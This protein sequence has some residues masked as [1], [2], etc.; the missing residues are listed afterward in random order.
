M[1]IREIVEATIRKY[2]TR[3]PYEL[4][5]LTGIKIVRCELGAIRGYYFKKFRFKQILL[6]C[7]LEHNDEKF[8]LAHEI[9]HSIMHPDTNTNF[10]KEHTVL[11]TQRLE[12]EANKFAVELL[13]PNEVILENWQYTTSQLARLTGYTEELIKLRLK[14]YN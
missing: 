8:V 12:I 14:D 5:D 4:A 10:W 3:S 7:N 9:G 13:I 11:S 6:N 1:N 2:N